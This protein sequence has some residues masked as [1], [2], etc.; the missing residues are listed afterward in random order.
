M[1]ARGI[2][3]LVFG[4]TAVDDVVAQQPQPVLEE[5]IVTATRVETNL[6]QTPMS[7]EAF[8]GIH[9]GLKSSVSFA[10]GWCPP[11]LLGACSN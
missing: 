3:G 8:T 1:S 10:I 5:I 7:I 4:L 2:A 11:W 6:Q 9:L